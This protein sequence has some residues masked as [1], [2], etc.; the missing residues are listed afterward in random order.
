MHTL[1]GSPPCRSLEDTAVRGSAE[2][3]LAALAERAVKQM[4]P[5]STRT[6]THARIDKSKRSAVSTPA[7]SACLLI[8]FAVILPDRCQ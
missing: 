1:I 3:I 2:P 8:S 4:L 6:A 5:L 7:L